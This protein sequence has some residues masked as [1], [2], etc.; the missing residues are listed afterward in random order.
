MLRGVIWLEKV[1]GCSSSDCSSWTCG[2]CR[3]NAPVLWP[4]AGLC[5][6][7]GADVPPPVLW[8]LD[9]PSSLPLSNK[10]QGEVEAPGRAWVHPKP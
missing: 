4:C 9:P 8:R 2:T 7:V 1:A 5:G 6:L 10:G 3:V